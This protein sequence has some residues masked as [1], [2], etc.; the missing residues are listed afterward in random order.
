M[1]IQKILYWI[2]TAV[3]TAIMCFSVFNY[4]ANYE[5]IAGY[6]EHFQYPV[7]LVYPLA[8]AKILGLIAVWGNFSKW[9]KEWAYAGFFFDTVLAFFAHYISDGN[10][11]LF[12]LI[13]L[14][15]TLISY[16]TGK[17]VRP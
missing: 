13:A 2:A 5:A 4:F 8:I 12:S 1:N 15:A 3:L 9:L 10:G 14:T 6:F 11:Y 16:F 17:Q 7:Y